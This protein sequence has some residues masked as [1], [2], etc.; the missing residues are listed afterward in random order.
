MHVLIY[1]V[2]PWLRTGYGKTV[3]LLMENIPDGDIQ[4]DIA[5]Y[6]GIQGTA[7][8]VG[9]SRVIPIYGMLDSGSPQYLAYIE[10]EIRPDVILQHFDVWI[11]PENWIA[12]LSA[13]VITYSP[14]DCIPIPL[15]TKNS[16][17]GA[18]MNVAMSRFAEDNYKSIG[19]P[20]TYIPHTFDP[21]IFYQL[22]KKEAKAALGIEED[23]FI[24]GLVGTNKS[25]R[26][27]IHGQLMAYADLIKYDKE[28][29]RNSIFYLH[30]YIVGN[31]YN[32]EGVD[33]WALIEQLG[34]Q[35]NIRYTEQN[36]YLKGLSD[37]E[38]Q[39]FYSAFDVLMSC[40]YG[41]GFCI[42]LIE[43][44]ACGTP[45]IVTDFSAMP[46][47]IGT[48]GITVPVGEYIY[49]SRTNAY[50]AIPRTDHITDAMGVIYHDTEFRRSLSEA[51]MANAEQYTLA[52][53][54]P[55]WRSLL[56]RLT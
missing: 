13:P 34:I 7:L 6:F 43:A 16:A 36:A 25:T 55:Q 22:D 29:R 31:E 24:Y 30:T 27:N 38:M 45:A 5:A 44:G 11:L 20:T 10:K 4:I 33:L 47:V 3:Q 26:K 54:I 1:S 19:A 12:S 32:N 48:G 23:K 35:D 28:I 14:I 46:E 50:H 51:A 21:S 40:S 8:T 49:L 42:P 15:R 41:E 37:K 53:V 18:A 2:A 52:K 17:R 56:S 9:E 39:Y